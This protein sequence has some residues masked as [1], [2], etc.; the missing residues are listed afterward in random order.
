MD[1]RMP[2]RCCSLSF[3]PDWNLSI[4]DIYNDAT[5]APDHA[6]SASKRKLPL[7]SCRP[8]ELLLV[9]LGGSTVLGLHGCYLAIFVL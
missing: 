6:T 9:G 2:G 3:E 8:D 5:E 7:H 4:P 1:P